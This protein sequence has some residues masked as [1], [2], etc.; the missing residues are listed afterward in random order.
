MP[1]SVEEQ[2][3]YDFIKGSLPSWL[4]A[5]PRVEEEMGALVK[6]GD[7]ARQQIDYLHRQAQILEADG[8]LG[9]DPDWLNQHAVDRGTARQ[10]GESDD[11]LR[12]RLRSFEDTVTVPALLS[13]IN[14]MLDAA[15]VASNNYGMVELRRDRAYICTRQQLTGTASGADA[16]TKVGTTMTLALAGVTFQGGMLYWDR[17]AVAPRVTIAGATS[18]GNNGTFALTGFDGDSM[19]WTNAAGV[20]EVF[21]GTWT[22]NAALHNRRDSYVNRGY[23]VGSQRPGIASITP[24]GTTENL[25][26]AIHEAIRQ[27]KAGGVG[28]VTERRVSP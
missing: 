3:V 28:H 25:R 7:L 17:G 2:A 26:L 22:I 12:D 1:L 14:S 8:P 4:F 21:G 15:G 27:R 23:R 13:L 5:N 6:A 9:S 11:A 19:Q 20:A 10:P 24:F 18:G 16:F